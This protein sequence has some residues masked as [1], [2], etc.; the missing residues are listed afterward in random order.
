V[1]KNKRNYNQ[2]YFKVGG[3][4]QPGEQEMPEQNKQK[5]TRQR[6]GVDKNRKVPPGA[7]GT[8]PDAES[9]S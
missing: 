3:S 7:P 2:D 9:G 1:T 5:L 4:A 6:K 8:E